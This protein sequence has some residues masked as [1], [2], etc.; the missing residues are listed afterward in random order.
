[1]TSIQQFH[2]STWYVETSFKTYNR[3]FE[4]HRNG[5][6]RSLSVKLAGHVCFDLCTRVR[7]RELSYFSTLVPGREHA[8]LMKDDGIGRPTALN[9]RD[10]LPR[11]GLEHVA[12]LIQPPESLVAFVITF[13]VCDSSTE[14]YI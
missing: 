5:Q 7:C 1:M 14:V 4:V 11:D 6:V 13:M 10:Q 8:V 2:H 12:L 9:M 3:D